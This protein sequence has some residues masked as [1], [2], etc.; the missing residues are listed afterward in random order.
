M[1]ILI[2]I[3]AVVCALALCRWTP[4]RLFR[5]MIVRPVL[6]RLPIYY[7]CDCWKTALLSAGVQP[8]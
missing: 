5:K 6:L 2:L 3:P 4:P 8:T 7:D 1:S